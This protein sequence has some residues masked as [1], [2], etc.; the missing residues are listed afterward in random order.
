MMKKTRLLTMQILFTVLLILATVLL[1]PGVT[2][3]Y[4]FYEGPWSTEYT[5]VEGPYS[6]IV[7]WS[8]FTP[9]KYIVPVS[10]SGNVLGYSFIS[11]M[12]LLMLSL[13]IKIIKKIDNGIKEIKTDSQIRKEIHESVIQKRKTQLL[14]S[15]MIC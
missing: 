14:S 5:I 11:L 2:Y 1:T 10:E 13:L 3:S 8:K 9:Q 7:T 4:S 6:T 12:L 15:Q